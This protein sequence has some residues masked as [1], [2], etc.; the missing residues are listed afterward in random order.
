MRGQVKLVVCT[1]ARK[2]TVT[3][4][5][6]RSLPHCYTSHDSSS[7]VYLKLSLSP[8]HDRRVRYKTN[9]EL[10]TSNA[11]SLHDTFSFDISSQIASKR[12]LLSAWCTKA[13]CHRPTFIGCMSFGLK[14]ILK[15][16]SIVQ[17]WYYLLSEPLGREKHLAVR[18]VQNSYRKSSRL[19]ESPQ[20]KV[21][22]LRIFNTDEEEKYSPRYRQLTAYSET[23]DSSSISVISNMNST[24]PTKVYEHERPR[25]KPRLKCNKR[26]RDD[27]DYDEKE[28]PSP[29]RA[30]ML[31]SACASS[32]SQE[33]Q[34]ISQENKSSSFQN[35]SNLHA[36][37]KKLCNIQSPTAR[38]KTPTGR[39][40][41]R[42]KSY[43][44]TDLLLFR[45]SYFG[46]TEET[47]SSSEFEN[48][49]E[50]RRN[51]NTA[52]CK[53]LPNKYGPKNK[54][55]GGNYYR[56]QYS[57]SLTVQKPFQ[58]S[59]KQT[60]YA[61]EENNDDDEFITRSCLVEHR[62]R[63][64]MAR[65]RK[66]NAQR[67]VHEKF[68]D[69]SSVGKTALEKISLKDCKT[70]DNTSTNSQKPRTEAED[71][72]Y[73]S[74][75]TLLSQT[76]SSGL[77]DGEQSALEK[78]KTVDVV[79]KATANNLIKKT[80]S[81]H[82]DSLSRDCCYHSSEAD[83]V[84]AI[85]KKK[86]TSYDEELQKKRPN[87]LYSLKSWFQKKSHETSESLSLKKTQPSKSFSTGWLLKHKS[88]NNNNNNNH[89]NNN[90]DN[91][92]DDDDE[93]NRLKRSNSVKNNDSNTCAACNLSTK[94]FTDVI[95]NKVEI[96]AF[97]RFL[98][99]EFSEE[100]L[101]FWIDCENYKNAK[102]NKRQKVAVKI[103][104]RYLTSES[105]K[106]VNID[107]KIRSEI[108]SK[109]ITLSK[110]IFDDA[111]LHIFKL[112]KKDSFRR[113]QITESKNCK[114]RSLVH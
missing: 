74:V 73:H 84:V 41:I 14:K 81:S 45:M 13:Q 70:C 86:S 15:S 113:F 100:N 8:D 78:V 30:F 31:D 72:G 63:S 47:E 87:S 105:P 53:T 67:S 40:L 75:V 95:K 90:T 26:Q 23:S 55:S 77:S 101:D 18:I 85:Q 29:K 107:A 102:Q 91:N 66:L 94:S 99:N 57:Q 37:S 44:S 60:S 9:P 61:I 28:A 65:R 54:S 12:L 89:N 51:I 106:E 17:G 25:P 35:F 10:V 42:R 88:N 112:M 71:K 64:H 76:S 79:L 96:S 7:F 16:N 6:L 43:T 59:A 103:Y 34:I 98:Q 38:A 114:C 80:A 27:I 19:E 1:S 21:R 68:V 3:V 48:E 39:R 62:M 109:L 2:L 108:K 69:F 104:E 4:L 50:Q 11:V 46:N 20:L 82:F 49:A 22:T 58:I 24:K 83:P 36:K 92:N 93:A 97:R 56:V 33:K 111:Q 110:D 5:G 52:I 32:Q